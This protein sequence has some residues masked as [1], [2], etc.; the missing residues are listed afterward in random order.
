[1][2]LDSRTALVTQIA[3]AAACNALPA[4]RL[5]VTE[6]LST[7]FTHDEVQAILTI[8]KEMQ[9]Q[10]ISHMSHLADQLLR[11]PKKKTHDHGANCSCGCHHA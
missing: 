2:N 6:A 3:A 4:L 5:A 1:M 10:P 9:Q 7:G 11:E 8:A